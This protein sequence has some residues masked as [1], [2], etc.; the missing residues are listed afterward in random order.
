MSVEALMNAAAGFAD[1]EER[2]PLLVQPTTAAS[3]TNTY[4]CTKLLNLGF[5]AT[6]L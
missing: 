3:K 5:A 4:V 6:L 2:I 1:G